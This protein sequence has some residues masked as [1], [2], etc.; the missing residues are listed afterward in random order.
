ML[1]DSR[2]RH[3]TTSRTGARGLRSRAFDGEGLPTRR[4]AIVDRKW[5]DH[6]PWL[7]RHRIGKANSA[8]PPPAM[9]AAAAAHRVSGA[10]NLTSCGP[11]QAEPCGC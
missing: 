8:S 9:P 6:R 5:Q 1:F 4:G 3:P 7:C 10:S 2:H 11:A